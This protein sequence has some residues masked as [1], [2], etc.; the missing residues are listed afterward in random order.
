MVDLGLPSILAPEAPTSPTGLR[1]RKAKG[2]RIDHLKGV[3]DRYDV[4]VIGSGLGGLTAANVLARS[5]KSVLLL[6][7]H[8]NFGGLATWFKR[9]H[10]HVFDISLHGFPAGMIK[11]CRKYW[12][13]EIAAS[14]VR[15]RNIRFDNPEFRIDTTFDSEDFTR[16]LIE[17]FAVP[18]DCV[19]AFFTEVRGMDFYADKRETTRELFERHFPGRTDVHRLLMEPIAYANGSTLD[20][21][22]KSYG[23]VFANFMKS[24]VYIFRGGTD[25]LIHAMKGEL[26]RNHVVLRNH[27][28]VERVLLRGGRVHGVR[29][30]G[31]NIH[32]GAVVSNASLH[33]TVTRLIA[34]EDAPAGLLEALE[35]VRVNTSSCQVYLGIRRGES[36]PFVA[37]LL[38][39]S[40][41]PRFD[42]EALV[43]LDCTSRTYSFY[44]PE[45]RPGSDRYAVVCSTNARYED[46]QAMGPQKYRAQ[47]EKLARES[48][49]ILERHV[50]GVTEKIDHVE[51]ATPR[52]FEF[53]TQHPLGA[54]FGTKFEGL[55]VSQA[56]P[57]R[58]PGLF[59]AG[60]V[61]IIMSGW[62]GAANYGVIVANEVDR[63]LMAD[64]RTYR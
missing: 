44:D 60:S 49:E 62:L 26:E 5:G 53:F 59:H 18:P 30:N 16:L 14:I 3:S 57:K 46:W 25:R 61:G 1:A 10:G 39:T 34:P 6:E 47:K 48:I 58:V 11:T 51:V 21:P 55:A 29:V 36:L 37:E 43:G 4:I 27:A 9:K 40:T 54:S 50:P 12:S 64:R 63:F 28:Q 52:T 35:P 19:A 41:A 38:F 15:L 42:S 33:A 24:G 56:L 23:I 7:Q 13:P 31:R 2:P 32:A 22:A 17:R 20:D 45:I 8:Y